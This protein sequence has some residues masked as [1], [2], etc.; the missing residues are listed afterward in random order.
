MRCPDCGS[1][2]LEGSKFCSF[3][4][5]KLPQSVRCPSCGGENLEGAKFCNLCGRRFDTEGGAKGGAPAAK[6][7]LRA[8]DSGAGEG[9]EK[10]KGS[11]SATQ[12]CHVCHEPTPTDN[13]MFD[14]EGN[15]VCKKCL[16]LGS[17]AKDGRTRALEAIKAQLEGTA[18]TQ[19]SHVTG[20][21]AQLRMQPLPRSD[22]KR[23]KLPYLGLALLLLG[24]AAAGGYY[25]VAYVKKANPVDFLKGLVGSAPSG[26]PAPTPS[27]K[28]E[29]ADKASPDDGKASVVFVGSYLG[30]Q[31][32]E[33]ELA[34]AMAFQSKTGEKVIVALPDDLKN[35][36]NSFIKGQ[37]YR[38]KF[39]PGEE[40]KETRRID[41]SML[42]GPI[43]EAK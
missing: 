1:E 10:K 31:A 12:F 16:L 36:A 9:I 3:C 30:P 35:L 4:S 39:K 14:L 6:G 32:G 42:E 37:T 40:F 13:L 24:A 26:A 41:L 2:N 22:E 28:S 43:K 25:Y 18:P 29:A 15:H 19:I 38:L 7:K 34:G 23:S 21:G 5:K 11:T 27:G 20:K 33:G 17:Q 8:T